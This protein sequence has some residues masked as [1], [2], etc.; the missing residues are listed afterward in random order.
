MLLTLLVVVCIWAIVATLMVFRNPFPFPDRGHRLYGVP[1]EHARRTVMNILRGSGLQPR[2]RFRTGPSDQTLFWD[3]E[4]V[5]HVLDQGGGL[6]GTGISVVVSNPQRA[7]SNA[8]KMLR[9]AGYSAEQPSD[10]AVSD[11]GASDLVVVASSAFL[12]WA[13][14]FRRHQLKMPKPHFLSP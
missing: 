2:L 12:G 8:I 14:A 10:A 13:L 3:N 5:I 1:N 6:S 7:A 9:D 4:T 11:V